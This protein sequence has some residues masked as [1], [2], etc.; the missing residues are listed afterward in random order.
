MK[1]PTR[2]FQCYTLSGEDITLCVYEESGKIELKT[3]IGKDVRCIEPGHYRLLAQNLS[4][5]VTLCAL[6]EPHVLPQMSDFIGGV[7][8]PLQ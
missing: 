7:H 5:S 2:V 1:T 4:S 6:R 3:G 8:K